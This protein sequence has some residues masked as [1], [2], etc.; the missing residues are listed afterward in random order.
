MIC[1]EVTSDNNDDWRGLADKM[2]L[3]LDKIRWIEE[4]RDRSPTEVL[5]NMWK[6]KGK[7]IEELRNILLEMGRHDAV[8]V[9]DKC[10]DNGSRMVRQDAVSIIDK[11]KYG[12]NK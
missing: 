4:Q 5:L 6:D 3:L 9:I 8:S 7:S 1:L 12:A 11:G 10:K 2:G